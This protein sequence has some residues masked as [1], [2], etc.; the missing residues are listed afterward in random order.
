MT[1]S[2]AKTYGS[3]SGWSILCLTA[4]AKPD[5]KLEFVDYFQETLDI[6]LY[7]IGGGAEWTNLHFRVIQT[8][9]IQKKGHIYESLESYIPGDLEGGSIA[10]PIVPTIAHYDVSRTDC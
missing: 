6:D 1:C 3:G 4:T 7:V 9:K 8:T 2:T 5:V 10:Y